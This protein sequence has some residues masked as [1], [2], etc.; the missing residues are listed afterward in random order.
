M[1]TIPSTITNQ[2]GEGLRAEIALPASRPNRS[3][4]EKVMVSLL[5]IGIAAAWVSFVI[6]FIA[7]RS[8]GYGR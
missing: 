3:A 2:V 4:L 5:L 6:I 1:V 7:M 8:D